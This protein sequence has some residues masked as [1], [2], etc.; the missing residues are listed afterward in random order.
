MNLYSFKRG[1]PN[2]E[3]ILHLGVQKYH[4]RKS[5]RT[6]DSTPLDF[7]WGYITKILYKRTSNHIEELKQNCKSTV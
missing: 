7:F 3:N 4:L 6:P 2:F 1:I 5:P